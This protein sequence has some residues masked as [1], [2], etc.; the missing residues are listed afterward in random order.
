MK[1]KKFTLN[2]KIA[3]N[4][5]Q[6]EPFNSIKSMHELANNPIGNILFPSIKNH[7]S[8]LE[9]LYKQAKELSSL[10]DEFNEAFGELGWFITSSMNLELVKNALRTAD[11]KGLDEAELVLTNSIDEQYLSALLLRVRYRDIFET[12]YRLIDL[13]KDDYLAGRYHSCI[14]LL[15]SLIDGIVND[16]TQHVGIFSENVDVTAYDSLAGHETGLQSIAKIFRT[17]RKKTNIEPITIPYRNGIMHGKDLAFDNKIV[18]AK[19]WHLLLAIVDWHN[20]IKYPKQHKQEKTLKEV[21]EDHR[22]HQ[23]NMDDFNKRF[24]AYKP[25][26]FNKLY[27]FPILDTEINQVLDDTPEKCVVDFMEHLKLHRFGLIAPILFQDDEKR[28]K[29]R[30]SNIAKDFK[31][32]KINHYKILDIEDQ[33][34]ARSFLIIAVELSVAQNDFSTKQIEVHLNYMDNE[35]NAMVRDTPNG[36]WIILPS[37]LQ[38]L[39]Y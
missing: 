29:Q 14:P 35:G 9:K 34:P 21:L 22:Q 31:G 26:D 18:A 28:M 12:R 19:C 37:V 13:A 4:P 23:I 32:V 20:D 15:L 6:K 16:L 30:I 39:L 1:K 10:P 5:S 25:R 38:S 2:A 24:E 3:D 27:K 36:Q 11:L 33:A 7:K 8:E 17:S